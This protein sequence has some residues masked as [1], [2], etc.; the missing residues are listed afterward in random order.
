MLH[1]VSAVGLMLFS[2][3]VK[4]SSTFCDLR[5]LPGPIFT[6][7]NIWSHIFS[8]QL[9]MPQKRRYSYPNLVA[10]NSVDKVMEANKT[11]IKTASTL[12]TCSSTY[13]IHILVS[14]PG[15]FQK[16]CTS[17]TKEQQHIRLYIHKHFHRI[18]TQ[19]LIPMCGA[20]CL[21]YNDIFG[22]CAACHT[23]A[24]H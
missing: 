18:T 2:C 1:Q 19:Q 4:H 3:T 12:K 24:V 11:Y 8:E 16:S 6:K 9:N 21:E 5:G 23:L 17:K 20:R 13:R 7:P 10:I 22:T 14:G 15:N